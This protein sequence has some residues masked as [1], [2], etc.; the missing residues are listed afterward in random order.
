[1]SQKIKWLLKVI[2]DVRVVGYSSLKNMYNK[3]GHGQ[4]S[5][6]NHRISSFKFSLPYYFSQ[7]NLR[8]KDSSPPQSP[9]LLQRASKQWILFFTYRDEQ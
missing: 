5:G 2:I 4:E 1:M 9:S 8:A 6:E 3:S 7:K